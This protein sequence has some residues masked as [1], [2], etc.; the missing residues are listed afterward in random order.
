MHFK[1]GVLE[2]LPPS[3]LKL[4]KQFQKRRKKRN[5]LHHVTDKFFLARKILDP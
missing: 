5:N 1:I 2:G 4:R 3:V